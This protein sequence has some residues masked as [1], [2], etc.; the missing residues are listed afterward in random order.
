VRFDPI[1]DYPGESFAVAAHGAIIVGNRKSSEIEPFRW[2]NTFIS[3]LKTAIGGTRRPSRRQ[4]RSPAGR[5]RS[6]Q[7]TLTRTLR[8]RSAALGSSTRSTPFL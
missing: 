4:S 1:D 3:N 2:V 7:C 8:R 5:R 6:D